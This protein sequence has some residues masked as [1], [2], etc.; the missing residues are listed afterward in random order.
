MG[1]ESN[2]VWYAYSRLSGRA[3]EQMQPWG[4]I[5][6]DSKQFTVNKFFEQM[7]S[8]FQDPELPRRAVAKLGSMRQ[9]K[10]PLPEFIPEF[11]RTLLEAKAGDWHD[12]VKI[13]Y[14]RKGLSQELVNALIF[15][16]EPEEYTAFC[17]KSKLLDQKREAAR[18]TGYPHPIL[19]NA[20]RSTGPAKVTNDW[21]PALS[22]LRQRRAK[23]VGDEEIAKRRR[24]RRCVRCGVSGHFIRDCIF[25][26]ARR[27]NTPCPQVQDLGV[28]ERTAE[29]EPETVQSEGS[30]KA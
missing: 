11:D 28:I 25:Q 2:R 26:P 27:P 7:Q 10:Q 9:G 14:L 29:L 17:S 24:E 21:E 30:G 22:Q 19:T 5:F 20:Q 1:E 8:A 16:D 23:W 6:A 13:N 12:A 15:V 3:A 18:S 4:S